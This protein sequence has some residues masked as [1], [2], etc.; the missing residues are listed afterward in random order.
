MPPELK[1]AKRSQ[2]VY[3]FLP[4]ETKYFRR[5]PRMPFDMVFIQKQL[6]DSKL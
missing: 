6:L 4:S 5:S 3:T 2:H 1:P